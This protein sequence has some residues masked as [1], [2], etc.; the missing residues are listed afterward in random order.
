MCATR[1][2][3]I[4]DDPFEFADIPRPERPVGV[5]SGKYAAASV[6]DKWDNVHVKKAPFSGVHPRSHVLL[7][8]TPTILTD[9]D[10][11]H[12]HGQGMVSKPVR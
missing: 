5:D 10:T 11:R 2:K 4:V 8:R 6:P 7:A 12:P 3:L 9:D 1:P